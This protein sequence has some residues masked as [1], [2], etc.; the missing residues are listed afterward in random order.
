M[1]GSYTITNKRIF[2]YNFSMNFNKF[3]MFVT[4]EF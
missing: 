2:F 1:F 4:I 3:L